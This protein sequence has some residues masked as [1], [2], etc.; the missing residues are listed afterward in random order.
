[1]IKKL[2]RTAKLKLHPP[3]EMGD[4]RITVYTQQYIETE[5]DLCVDYRSVADLILGVVY[6][7][8]LADTRR[9]LYKH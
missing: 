5:L 1:M 6:D 3:N 9:R 8:Q 4:S 2:T 7:H